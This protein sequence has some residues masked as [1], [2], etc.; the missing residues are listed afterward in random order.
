MIWLLL[1]CHYVDDPDDGV[2]PAWS[3]LSVEGQLWDWERFEDDAVWRQSLDVLAPDATEVATSTTRTTYRCDD[4]GAWATNKRE[5][6]GEQWVEWTY[7]PAFLV[8]PRHLSVGDAW[9]SD[10]A[11]NL[12]R[13]DGTEE[14]ASESIQFVVEDEVATI[15]PAGSFDALQVRVLGEAGKDTWYFARDV[16]VVLTDTAQLLGYGLPE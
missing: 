13:S 7:D 11:W 5:T 8:V 14:T 12:L 3:G 10:A 1:A 15:V 2:C 16:G 6:S 4:D 9:S